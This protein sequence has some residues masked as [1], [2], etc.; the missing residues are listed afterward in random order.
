MRRIVGF[1]VAAL[2]ALAA[3][4]GPVAACDRPHNTADWACVFVS[5]LDTGYCQQNPLPQESLVPVPE[6]AKVVPSDVPSLSSL[7]GSL[8][9]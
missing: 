9:L 5:Q 7:A 6:E 4:T 3:L 1:V 8:G 2:A